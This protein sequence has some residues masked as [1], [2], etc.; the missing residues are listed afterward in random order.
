MLRAVRPQLCDSVLNT[1]SD[2]NNDELNGEKDDEDMEDGE[3]GFDDGIAQWRNIRYPGQ[4]TA[5]ARPRAH[6]HT[7]TAQA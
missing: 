3:T 2:E 6:D 7:L 4:P 5:L 1:T